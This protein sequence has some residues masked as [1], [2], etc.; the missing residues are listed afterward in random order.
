MFWRG[1]PLQTLG[2]IS[3]TPLVAP[4]DPPAEQQTEA[5]EQLWLKSLRDPIRSVQRHQETVCCSVKAKNPPHTPC[6]VP[7]SAFMPVVGWSSGPPKPPTY[8]LFACNTL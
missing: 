1:H 3:S 4:Y 8:L 7:A 2:E 6:T 5:W